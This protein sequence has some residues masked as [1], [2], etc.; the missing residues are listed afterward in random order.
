MS[1]RQWEISIRSHR[2][3]PEAGPFEFCGK[4]RRVVQP[5]AV[6]F[7]VTPVV[8]SHFPETN[9]PALHRTPFD[10][11]LPLGEHGPVLPHAE[12]PGLAARRHLTRTKHVED[13]DAAGEE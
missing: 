3:N 12:T 5:H 7:L 11:L 8:L 13:E 6:D 1:L 10:V 2:P 4:I 9:D